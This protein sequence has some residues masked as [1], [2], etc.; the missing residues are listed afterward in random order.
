MM[1]RKKENSTRGEESKQ[2]LLM[3]SFLL[4][5]RDFLMAANGDKF[6][7]FASVKNPSIPVTR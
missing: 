1:C 4:S 2:E 3:L 7:Y 5:V 6:S